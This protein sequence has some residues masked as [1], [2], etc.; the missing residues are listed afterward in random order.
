MSTLI[1]RW[2]GLEVHAIL[3]SFQVMLIVVN[4]DHA[5]SVKALGEAF[6]K[7]FLQMTYTSICTREEN[8]CH[9]VWLET[10]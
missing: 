9:G 5:A 6:S 3:R 7:C 4:K 10:I 2:Q 1:K 8:R